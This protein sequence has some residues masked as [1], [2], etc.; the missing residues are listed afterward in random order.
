[1]DATIHKV[2]GFRIE[3]SVQPSPVGAG[4]RVIRLRKTGVHDHAL[5]Q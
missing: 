1:M 5:Y 3:K 4:Q 2:T